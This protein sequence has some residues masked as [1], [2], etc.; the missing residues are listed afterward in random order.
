MNANNIFKFVSVRPPVLDT[1]EDPRFIGND[2][3]R[4]IID[5]LRKELARTHDL[6]R[7]R[8]SLGSELM[9]DPNYY[10][11]QADWKSLR[12]STTDAASILRDMSA[13]PDEGE[14]ESRV[15][16]LFFTDGVNLPSDLR[17]FLESD[18][19]DGLISSLWLSYYATVLN[20]VPRSQD[21]EEMLVWFQLFE[22]LKLVG[23]KQEFPAAV[24]Q[25]RRTRPA[26][27]MEFYRMTEPGRVSPAAPSRGTP[28]SD[29]NRDRILQLRQ[30]IS[31]LQSARDQ[32]NSAYANKLSAFRTIAAPRAKPAVET[33]PV[34]QKPSERKAPGMATYAGLANAPWRVAP[35]DFEGAERQLEALRTA[36]L[37]PRLHNFPSLIDAT[38]RKIAELTAN[39]G[40]ATATPIVTFAGRVAVTTFRS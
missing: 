33:T 10:T 11:T 19:Y 31:D 15:Q 36:G 6:D 37:D 1:R 30:Q 27:P 29:P 18:V 32:L 23:T 22:L 24:A 28:R 5:R 21:R 4:E 40:A 17:T 9:A 13:T 14:F 16:S 8:L 35:Q 3:Q 7:A 34:A 25:A 38:E 20:P 12:V 2:R 26:V 39:L